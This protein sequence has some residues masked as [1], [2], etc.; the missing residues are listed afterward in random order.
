MPRKYERK[1]NCRPRCTWTEENLIAAMDEMKKKAIGVNQ[2]ARNFG[3]PS[4]TLRR[5]FAQHETRKLTLGLLI[6]ELL[7]SCTFGSIVYNFFRR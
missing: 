4:R 6:I 2:I 1:A 5:R 7:F 3:I